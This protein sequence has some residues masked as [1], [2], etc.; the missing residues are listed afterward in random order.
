MKKYI[1][2]I[3]IAII[4]WSCTEEIVLDDI[5]NSTPRLVV[6]AN[7]DWN[8]NDDET[9]KTQTIK[10]TKSTSYYSQDYPV[11]TNATITVTNSSDQS[12]GT[13]AY[14]P[15][16]EVYLSTDFNKPVLGETY[17]IK[18]EVDGEVYTANDTY[19]SIVDP[20]YIRQGLNTDFDPDGIINVDYNIDNEIG[21]DNYYLFKIEPPTRVTL[22]PEYSNADDKLISEEPGKNNYDFTYL[23]EELEPGDLLKITTYGISQR[24][25]DYMNK[26]LLTAEGSSG[27]FSTTPATIRGNVLN[28][29]DE[30]NRAF[31]YFS[32]NQFTYLEYTVKAK[33]EE[34]V[35]TEY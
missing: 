3:L 32:I 24:Y 25:N 7:I 21:V 29:T 10:L 33:S 5:L 13:F 35:V 1:Y 17:F 31:G 14:D 6:E 23:E 18:I 12:M 22:L 28:E 16:L 2:T 20:N 26:L 19:T 8:K 15:T 27:P 11:V 34:E 4:S 9:S 30:E